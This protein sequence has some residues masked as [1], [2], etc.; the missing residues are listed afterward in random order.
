[1]IVYTRPEC[2]FC[3]KL[4]AEILPELLADFRGRLSVERRPA[5]AGLP[6]PTILVLGPGGTQVFPGLPS[7]ERLGAAISLTLGEAR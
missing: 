3:Q 4:E 5:E 2:V 1:M 7:R 6:T